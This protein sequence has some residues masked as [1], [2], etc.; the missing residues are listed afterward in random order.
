VRCAIGAFGAAILL[1]VATST[2]GLADDPEV[3]VAQKVLLEPTTEIPFPIHIKNREQ[4]PKNSFLRIRGDLTGLK[5]SQGHQI[6]T[7][8]WAIPIGKLSELTI[9]LKS[10]LKAPRQ[11][12]V[13]LVALDGNSFRSF[14]M[15]DVTL[16]GSA[17]QLAA[18]DR[19]RPNEQTLAVMRATSNLPV[20]AERKEK[21]QT[22]RI[23]PPPG[24]APGNP[25][26]AARAPVTLPAAPKVPPPRPALSPAD[27]KRA[28]VLMQHGRNVLANGDV[29][30]ARLFFERAAR[31]GL[32]EAALAMAETFDPDEL[33]RIGVLGIRPDVDEA[34]KWYEEA[35]ALGE[36]EAE[37]RLR[38]LNANY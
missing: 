9:S 13:L 34:R 3:M 18:D 12:R 8:A 19:P 1:S 14:A 32:G 21:S 11:L 20:G 26:F 23:R 36:S 30:S 25:K 37:R 2:A 10:G 5:L 4:L 7:S 28:V 15:S 35:K 22:E 31:I 16:Y 17:Q 27:H 29:V 38:R 33:R 24:G 6:S